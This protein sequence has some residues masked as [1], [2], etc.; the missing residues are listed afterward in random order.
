MFSSATKRL[1]AGI[2]IP[3][4]DAVKSKL[5]PS[6]FVS[7]IDRVLGRF[8]HI[9]V[10]ATTLREV[11]STNRHT[12]AAVAWI[13]GHTY[14]SP[15]CDLDVYDRVGGGDGFVSGF[16]YGLLTEESPEAALKLGWAHGAMLTTF[17]VIRRWPLCKRYGLLPK[18]LRH[19]SSVEVQIGRETFEEIIA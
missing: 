13:N 15:S 12:W 14:V 8:P 9:K 17:P 6:A 10:I 7:M 11:H 1:A 2:G 16:V 18:E 4:P 3:G 5:D 19:A